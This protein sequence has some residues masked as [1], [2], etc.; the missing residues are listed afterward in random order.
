MA[1]KPN[2][3]YRQIKGPANTRKEYMGG[4]PASRITKFDLGQLD[5]SNFSRAITMVVKE[6][7]QIRHNALESARIAANKYI[8]K[9][10]G[11]KGYHLKVRVYP[12]HILRENKQATGAGADR[13]SQ[14]MRSA[15]GKS[16]ST[17]SRVHRGQKIMTIF[18]NDPNY[19]NAKTALWK[20]G[21]KIPS[22]ISI[23]DEDF[24]EK[25]DGDLE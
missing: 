12:H 25:A 1:R 9:K 6:S 22:P 17:A 10:V 19:E 15:F 20:A 14:G 21:Q 13:I 11:P 3:M 5:N 7:V 18:F 16:V 8:Q 2:S 4:T 24:G 23:I